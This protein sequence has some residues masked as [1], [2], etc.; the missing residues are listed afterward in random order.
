MPTISAALQPSS[1]SQVVFQCVMMWS[2]LMAKVATGRPSKNSDSAMVTGGRLGTVKMA[3][4]VSP[5]EDLAQVAEQL[6][7]VAEDLLAGRVA[8]APRHACKDSGGAWSKAS[9]NRLAASVRSVAAVL[10][11][12]ESMRTFLSK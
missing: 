12:L 11:G 4:M 2:V 7:A 3:V 5:D 9:C 6:F 1:C 10:C 8:E